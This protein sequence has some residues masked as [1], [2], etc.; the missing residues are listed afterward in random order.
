MNQSREPMPL[1]A[2]HTP[3][4]AEKALA[5]LPELRPV[6]RGAVSAWTRA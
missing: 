2:I 6:D 1:L 4:G 5:G 3:G